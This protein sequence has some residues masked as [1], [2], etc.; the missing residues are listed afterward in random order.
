MQTN[1]KVEDK[2]SHGGKREGSGRKAGV[3]NKMSMTVKENVIQV[4][5]MLGGIEHMATWASD[6]PN[7][8]YAIYSKLMPLQTE[9]SGVDGSPIPLSIGIQLIESSTNTST[10]SE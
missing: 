10:V 2:S 1:E 3:P 6:N 8:F 7:Q 5:D 4:F 9:I